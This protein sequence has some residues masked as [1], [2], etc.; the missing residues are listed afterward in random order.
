MKEYNMCLRNW[1]SKLTSVDQIKENLVII[2]LVITKY[3]LKHYIFS[4]DISTVCMLVYISV[5]FRKLTVRGLNWWFFDYF[6]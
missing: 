5:L 6:L 2:I 4:L 1:D 3:I